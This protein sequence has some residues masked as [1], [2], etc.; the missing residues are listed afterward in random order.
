MLENLR[1]QISRLQKKN[2][3]QAWLSDEVTVG[4]RL[5]SFNSSSHLIYLEQELNSHIKP[6]Q[7]KLASMSQ[8]GERHWRSCDRSPKSQSAKAANFDT[9]WLHSGQLDAGVQEWVEKTLQCSQ[10]RPPGGV[11]GVQRCSCKCNTIFNNCGCFCFFQYIAFYGKQMCLWAQIKYPIIS[12]IFVSYLC[13][14]FDQGSGVKQKSTSFFTFNHSLWCLNMNL[15]DL[16]PMGLARSTFIGYLLANKEVFFSH[17]AL[18][19]LDKYT[20]SLFQITMC[21]NKAKY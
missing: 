10:T 16:R 8:H 15:V 3:K 18:R 20:D 14:L 7:L 13:L 5:F 17:L 1:V 4:R 2:K 9:K 11:R 12:Q 21:G 19:H 6:A